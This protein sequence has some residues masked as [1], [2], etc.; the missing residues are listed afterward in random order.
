M[1]ETKIISGLK[2]NDR[3]AFEQVFDTY[4][5]QVHFFASRLT[6]DPEEAR[7]IVMK[8]FSR[9]WTI[10]DN[11][12]SLTN[13]KA[14]L[15]IG[16]KNHCLDYLKQLQRHQEGK[17]E[18]RS[19]MNNLADEKSI[20]R[21][22]IEAD[23]INAI[24]EKVEGLPKKCREIFKLT[25]F[26]GLKANEIAQKLNISVSTV[27]T[28]RSIAIKYLREVLTDEHFLLLCILLKGTGHLY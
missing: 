21:R 17:Q 11:F 3:P 7:D 14:F 18:Y 1:N 25:Y 20:E 22:L 28:Q 10:R 2:N 4:F 19:L 13:I 15:Y 12:E 8:V 27:T 16:T 24:Y 23:I 9:F 5:P 6:G 26:D